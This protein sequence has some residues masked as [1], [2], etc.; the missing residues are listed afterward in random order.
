MT[1]E[2][3][4]ESGF[5]PLAEA[6]EAGRLPGAILGVVDNSGG[7]AVRWAG[8]AALVPQ[9]APLGRGTWYDLASLT[10]VMLTVPGILRLLEAGK[11]DL[12]DPLSR[13]LPDM[14]QVTGEPGLRGLTLLQLLT[15][16]S[17]LPAWAPLYSWGNDP[18]TLKA[19]V[20]QRDWTL[21]PIVYSDIGYILLGLVIERLNGC[22]LSDLPLESGLAVPPVAEICAAT[23]A[24]PW[25]GRVLRGETHDE[26]AFALGG[27]AGH[28]GLFGTIDGVL[29]FA[30]GVLGGQS[31][32]PA[33]IATMRQRRT[34]TRALGWQVPHDFAEPG[35]PS[36]TG[37]TL[38]S[39]A[40]IGHAGFTGTGLWLDFD[41]LYGWV[42][43]TNRVHPSRHT[44]TGIQDLKR[45]VGN[46]LAA[47][48]SG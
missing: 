13:H 30:A 27:V 39:P 40:T 4:V 7:R 26:N 14:C 5:V 36:W 10:K 47:S 44:D 11:L 2:T 25:R 34:A 48:W 3:M 19:L 45:A 9:P 18:A 33:S 37:G 38:C 12:S 31:L 17:G 6:V 23:E 46:R 15:H 24:C 29:D 16:D 42:V 21:G 20:L 1:L 41:R 32:S 8:R 35:Q 22:L 43:L 28:A